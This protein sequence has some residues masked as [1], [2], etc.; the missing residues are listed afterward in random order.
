M[1]DALLRELH[2]ST[3]L[4]GEKRMMAALQ[5]QFVSKGLAQKAQDTV[6]R[7]PTCLKV[8]LQDP[9]S[10]LERTSSSCPVY[11]LGSE[12][13]WTFCLDT[14][15]PSETRTPHRRHKG[16]MDSHQPTRWPKAKTETGWRCLTFV[17]VLSGT[18]AML[19]LRG[20]DHPKICMDSI[21][22]LT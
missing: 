21:G 6:R 5:P 10:A 17:M 1:A 3:H 20:L 22:K 14:S 4:G 9:R 13:S 12:G 2:E 11:P 7:C 16:Q 18:L 19:P 8:R 15:Q